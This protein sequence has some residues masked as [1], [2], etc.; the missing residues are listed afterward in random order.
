MRQIDAINCWLLD[1]CY[2]LSE[3]AGSPE[4]A[5]Y[6]EEIQD[7][8]SRTGAPNFAMAKYL[9]FLESEIRSLKARTDQL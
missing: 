6:L 9:L 2:D 7:C 4:E 3:H 1:P 5:E 8:A